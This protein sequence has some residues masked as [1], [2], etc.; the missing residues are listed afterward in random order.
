[1]RTGNFR[2][3]AY[4]PTASVR[5]SPFPPLSSGIFPAFQLQFS[6]RDLSVLPLGGTH[7]IW[8]EATTGMQTGGDRLTFLGFHRP[9]LM[10]QTELYKSDH[11]TWLQ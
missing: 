10:V 8:C 1:M 11:T 4:P 3:A 6:F 7:V 5:V 9:E 2:V